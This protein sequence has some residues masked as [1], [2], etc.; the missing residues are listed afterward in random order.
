MASDSPPPPLRPSVFISYASEDRAAARA[1]RDTLTAAG[2]EVWYDENELVGGDAWDQKI[3]R[4]IRDCDYFLPIISAATERRKEGYF[5]REWRLAAERTMDMADDVLFLLPVAIDNTSE[6]NARVP[7]KFLNVQWLR[8]PGGAATPA[9]AALTKRLLAGDHVALPRP[10]LMKRIPL[11]PPHLL[12][13]TTAP[14]GSRSPHRGETPQVDDSAADR[15]PTMPQF[16]SAPEKNGIGPWLKFMA[17]IIWWFVTAAWLLM[18]R[19]PRWARV[20][21]VIWI[22][23]S[24]IGTLR[25]GGSTATPPAKKRPTSELTAKASNE[26]KGALDTAKQ[27]GLDPLLHKEGKQARPGAGRAIKNAIDPNAAGKAL[28]LAP[29]SN[30][31]SD[32]SAI[33]FG[34]TVFSSC[35]EILQAARPGE[36]AVTVVTVG[37]TNEESLTAL[38]RNL[39]SRVILGGHISTTNG[40]STLSVLLIRMPAGTPAWSAEFPIKGTEEAAVAAKITT[41]VLEAVPVSRPKPPRPPETRPPETRD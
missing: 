26:V 39:G 12:D 10:P 4:Q 34:N 37:N 17:E 18:T 16:P 24:V 2:L 7:D 23:F 30:D 3:R 38:A 13:E 20:I 28:V 36:T 1:L 6:T 31:S 22:L 19:M 9:L 40:V 5:R 21:L 32:A 33:Q 8:L 27:A 29:F 35:S 25:F 15:P 14:W 11:V 41:A